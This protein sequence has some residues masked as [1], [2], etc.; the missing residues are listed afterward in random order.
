M[1]MDLNTMKLRRPTIMLFLLFFLTFMNTLYAEPNKIQTKEVIVIF[2]E[3]LENVAKDV[4]KVYPAVKA[5]LVAT[6]DWKVD[7]RPD[8]ILVKDKSTLMKMVGSD[9]I[10]AFAIP[11]RNLIVLDT[12]RIYTRPFTLEATLKHELCHILLHSNIKNDRLPRWLDE[13]VCQ[14]ASGGIAELIADDGDSAITKATISDSTISIGDL[15]RFP[16]DE[17]SLLLAYEESKSI[18]EYIV[19]EYGKQGILQILGYLKEGHSIDDSIQKSLSVS[20]SELEI[21]WLVYLK[22]KHTWFSYLSYNIYTILFFLAAVITVYGFIRL[23]KK[24]RAYVDE[25]EEKGRGGGNT[26]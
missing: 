26:S 8:V 22:R 17:K 12:S 18:V 4:V 1:F 3:P 6:L 11:D 25:D 5:D 20:T 7:V 2:E 21:K 24:K 13:G 16:R 10:I 23:L 9:I 19:S 15:I 14:W